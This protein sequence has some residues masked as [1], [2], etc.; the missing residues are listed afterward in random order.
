MAALLLAVLLISGTAW[1]YSGFGVGNESC[2]RWTEDKKADGPGRWQKKQWVAGYMTAY[3]L[4]VENGSG[5]VTESDA[6][7]AVAWIDNYCQETPLDDLADAAE[8][9]IYAIKAK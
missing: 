4:W 3:S 8:K 6:Y 2:G 7:G 9:M 5:P 1:A